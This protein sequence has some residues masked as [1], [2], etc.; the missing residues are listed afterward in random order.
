[1]GPNE[2]LQFA[3][4]SGSQ[5]RQDGSHGVNLRE[6]EEADAPFS[7]VAR[8]RAWFPMSMPFPTFATSYIMTSPQEALGI[9]DVHLP[10]KLFRKRSGSRA[11]GTLHLRN[12]LHVPTRV[13]C[14]QPGYWRL[15]RHCARGSWRRRQRC[16]NYR[17]R[18]PTVGQLQFP[19]FRVLEGRSTASFWLLAM[20]GKGVC[21][22]QRGWRHS[23][24]RADRM[25]IGKSLSGDDQHVP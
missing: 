18:W 4:G 25:L 14:W 6:H 24:V 19:G 2:R 7:S 12:V 23:R 10:V 3:V 8:D 22:G 21:L 20:H 13:N 15:F 11:H 17:S 1:M 5:W 16:G 9:G